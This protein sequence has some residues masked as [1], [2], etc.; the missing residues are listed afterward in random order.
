ML[1]TDLGSSRAEK[2]FSWEGDVWAWLKMA[3]ARVSLQVLG[4]KNL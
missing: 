4:P 2:G 1:S 3:C